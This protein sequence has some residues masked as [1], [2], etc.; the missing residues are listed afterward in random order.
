MQ[1]LARKV[2]FSRRETQGYLFASIFWTSPVHCG[3]IPNP[4]Y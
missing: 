2:F 4:G 1:E 3:Q